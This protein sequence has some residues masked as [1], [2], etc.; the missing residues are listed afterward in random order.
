MNT[1]DWSH[2]GI[3]PYR[4][5]IAAAVAHYK[6]IPAPVRAKLI[7]RMER[8]TEFDDV[9]EIRR[10]TIR[11]KREYANLSQ[12]HFGTGKMCGTVD[13]SMWA[14]AQVERGLVYCEDEH[15]L[16]VPTVCRNVSMVT[17]LPEQQE[18]PPLDPK[19]GAGP[20][21]VASAEP[22]P[23][24]AYPPIL[25]QA[26]LTQGYGVPALP[27]SPPSYGGGIV[28]PVGV[29]PE[30]PTIALLFAGLVGLAF[31]RKRK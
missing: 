10:D 14:D 19:P 26:P 11:G 13:R 29:V 25:E 1:C 21:P 31:W 23:T 12:M 28:G 17:R 20:G 7:R 24:V 16:I 4:G 6:D 9:A 22:A 30:P 5:P 27:Y 3:D 2:P 8:V 18:L 15:C